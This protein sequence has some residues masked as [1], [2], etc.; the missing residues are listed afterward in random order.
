MSFPYPY[1]LG[2]WACGVRRPGR[3]AEVSSNERGRRR[4]A[5]NWCRSAVL[6]KLWSEENSTC[7]CNAADHRRVR[8]LAFVLNSSTRQLVNRPEPITHNP[9]RITGQ[10][11]SGKLQEHFTGGGV[12]KRRKRVT[13]LLSVLLG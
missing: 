10:H 9:S 4:G 8:I 11:E 7:A 1:R 2:L 12:R 13:G 6:L 3:G 5:P